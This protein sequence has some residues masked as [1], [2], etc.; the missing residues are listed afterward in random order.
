MHAPYTYLNLRLTIFATLIALSESEVP[1]CKTKYP[2]SL[3][4]IRN[5]NVSSDL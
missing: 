4:L 5:T 2:R 1:I 3:G